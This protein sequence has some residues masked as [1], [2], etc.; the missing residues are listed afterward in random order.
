MCGIVGLWN[1]NGK[2]VRPELITRMRDT[3]T[4]RG[5]DDA[6]LWT[7]NGIGL[8]HRRLSI[9]DLSPLGHQPMF[10][11]ETG[12]AIIFNGEV[13]NFQEIRDELEALGV[14]FKSRTDTEVLLKAYRVWGEECVKRF[15]G[16]F[17]LAI[18]DKR[19]QQLFLAR[20]RLGIKPLYYFQ[21]EN[22]FV[23]ASR[24]GALN[25]HPD[26]PAEI[27]H[28]ALGLYLE[29]GFVPSPW[30]ILK[31]VKKL[32]PGHTL[33]IA[34]NKVR[35][36]CY[37]SLDELKID[38]SLER[39]SEREIEERLDLLLRQAVKLRLIADVPLGAFLSGGIDSSLVVALMKQV[40]GRTP[41][42]FT[43]GFNEKGFDESSHA[44]AISRHLGTEHHEK[45]MGSR[46]LLDLLDQNTLQ[47][48]EPFADWSSLPTMMVSRFAREHVT[49]CLSGDGGDE[50][51]AGYH[52]YPL[53]SRLRFFGYLPHPL[54]S[55]L[56][57]LLEKTGH[58][59]LTLLGKTIRRETRVRGFAFMR[60][61][62]KDFGRENLFDS[63]SLDLET[64]FSRRA[65][66]FSRLDEVSKTCRLDLAY[67]LPDDIL[68]KVDVASMA[69]SLEARVPILDHRV[70]EF[71]Q[72]LPIRFKLKFGQT[73]RLL[74]KVLGR[75]V[76]REL[77][78]R[79]KRGFCVPIDHWFRAELRDMLL[80]E[81]SPAHLQQFPGL[82]PEGVSRVVDLHLSGKR[83]THP[84][85]W[86]LLSLVRW[87]QEFS[88]RRPF[89]G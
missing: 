30:S 80:D 13:Y 73:K 47:Y 38:R 5:P 81:L 72:S 29:V 79:P 48:D 54:K 40:S 51:F 49:V 39:T 65:Q 69:Y 75:Y 52:Y 86:V 6:G 19:N 25:A 24:L 67:Y 88:K 63:P 31:G 34:R 84:L 37:W 17:A 15:V 22:M 74:K 56:S 89:P 50:L 2:P 85:L 33:L 62:I 76:P 4:V 11:E 58:H 78:E 60:S 42:T 9:I 71:S 36:T 1:R 59:G 57:G 10:D 32:R 27:D 28:E 77:F 53:V 87:K 3:M 23:F 64:L 46:D 20:D 66:G 18:W 16:M 68:Q 61:M 21:N 43:I 45:I 82:K 70:V 35:E 44:A 7:E 55:G 83:N 26:C 14:R 8:G 41:K 12:S